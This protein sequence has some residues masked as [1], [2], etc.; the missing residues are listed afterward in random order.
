MDDA[1]D[2]A[3]IAAEGV[4]DGMHIVGEEVLAA[5]KAI[6][7]F[8]SGRLAYITLGLAA[9]AAAGAFIG[10][11]IGY[12]KAQTKYSQIAATEI[13]EMRQ[14]Y[15]EKYVALENTVEK[16]K[17]ADIV[18]EQGYSQD[19]P[20]AVTPPNAVV[21]AVQEV[22][23]VETVEVVEE[24]VDEPEVRNV[25]RNAQVIDEWDDFKERQNRS[26]LLPYVI[27]QD[28]RTENDVY[29]EVTFTY[30]E[31][32]DVLCNE[33]DEVV[34]VEERER[35]IGEAN[36][37]RFGHGSGDGSIVYVRNDQLE[38]VFEV[39][40][41]PNSYAEEVHGFGPEIRHEDRQS[42]G[43]VHFDDE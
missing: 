24:V 10:F 41:S 37:E 35:L 25:F 3:N 39:I 14:H 29:D 26:P 1:K 38:I 5:E 28:E 2:I 33:R 27:H 16:P 43:R 12:G 31:E 36:L 7:T 40:R 17:L 9:G 20:M 34:D 32:D 15:N 11:R 22:E 18:K 13:A 4:A 30:Y 6:R 23:E 19:P 8:D 42:R 21:E